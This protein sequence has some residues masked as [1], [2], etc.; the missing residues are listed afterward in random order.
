MVALSSHPSPQPSATGLSASNGAPLASVRVSPSLKTGPTPCCC[1]G[2]NGHD[3]EAAV[4][5]SIFFLHIACAI[6]MHHHTF[7]QFTYPEYNPFAC[8]GSPEPLSYLQHAQTGLET[9]PSMFLLIS[10]IASHSASGKSTPD[11]IS[12]QT[13]YLL[14]SLPYVPAH[15]AQHIYSPIVPSLCDKLPIAIAT[16]SASS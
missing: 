16:I 6:D 13:S 12:K 10:L 8:S 3:L 7:L 2:S 9:P 5:S 14:S 15:I 4:P 11:E 1:T